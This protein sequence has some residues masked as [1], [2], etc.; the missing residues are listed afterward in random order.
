MQEVLNPAGYRKKN[1]NTKSHTKWNGR[2]ILHIKEQD[3]TL[4]EQL[5]EVEMGN[6]HEKDFRVMT[7]RMIQDLREKNGDKEWKITRNV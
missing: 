7:V 2:K 5:N 3:K 4:E 6:L 1:K